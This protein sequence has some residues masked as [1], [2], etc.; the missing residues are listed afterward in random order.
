MADNIEIVEGLA[1]EALRELPAPTHVFIGGSSGNMD[2]IIS[3]ILEKS[4]G[5]VRFVINCIAMESAAQALECAK[6]H[7]IAEPDISQVSVSRGHAVG[8]YTMMKSENPITIICFDGE[9]NKC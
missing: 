3:E 1:P 4:E 5:R 7:A 2:K 6:K 9:G 8:R